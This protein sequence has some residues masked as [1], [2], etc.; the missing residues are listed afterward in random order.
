MRRRLR[1]PFLVLPACGLYDDSSP[2]DDSFGGGGSGGAIS[3]PPSVECAPTSLGSQTGLLVPSSPLA[4]RGVEADGCDPSFPGDVQYS[5]T[6]PAAGCY[7]ISTVNASD[8]PAKYTLKVTRDTCDGSAVLCL[9]TAGYG[10]PLASSLEGE[11]LPQGE[12]LVIA[13]TKIE[14]GPAAVNYALAINGP[15]DCR[16]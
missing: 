14:T 12:R 6:A 7:R 15:H 16:F 10:G 1:V 5:W 11:Y 4:S 3:V 13:L 2:A 8:R 9:V